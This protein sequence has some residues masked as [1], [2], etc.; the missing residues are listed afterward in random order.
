[1]KRVLFL[2]IAVFALCSVND[3]LAC[4][5]PLDIMPQLD[6]TPTINCKK[7]GLLPIALL[8]SCNSSTGDCFCDSALPTL[9][10]TAALRCGIDD[11]DGLF[12]ENDFTCWWKV[13]DVCDEVCDGTT[14]VTYNPCGLF[15]DTDYN[16]INCPD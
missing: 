1:M 7:K 6:T 2:A 4:V 14:S 15:Q 11:A 13:S 10:G 9:E 3:L 8:F 5:G 16:A 12:G